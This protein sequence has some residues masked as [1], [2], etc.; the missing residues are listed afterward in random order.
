MCFGRSGLS[1]FAPR[2][3]FHDLP[4]LTAFSAALGLPDAAFSSA[5]S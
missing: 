1:S 2:F 3:L 5:R 4:L